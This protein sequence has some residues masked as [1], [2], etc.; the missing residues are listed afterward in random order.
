M[1]NFLHRDWGFAQG[2]YLIAIFPLL[3]ILITAL[4][5]KIVFK[6]KLGRGIANVL[7][8]IAK[9]S[10][11]IH[12]DKTYSQALTSALTVGFGGSA[13][14]EAPIVVTGAAIGSNFA[15]KAG[16]N[17]RERT[18]LLGAGS[19]AG[20]AAV[21]N[22]PITGVIFVIEVLLADMAFSEFIPIIISS[23][24][25]ALCSKVI[26]GENQL[27]V[28]KLK[29][30]FNYANVP[31][32]ILLGILS[33]F[34]SLYYAR[35]TKF[36]ERTFDK[37]A[38]NIFLKAFIG[39]A[40]LFV[41]TALFPS[42][43]GE[44]YESV[45][46]LADGASAQIF[47]HSAISSYLGSEWTFLIFIGLVALIKVIATAL[48]IGSGG[49][50]GNFAPSLFVGAYLGFF[51]S[52]LINMLNFSK[53]PE[54]NFTLVGMAGILSGVFYAPFTAIFLIAELTGGYE[55]I[56][57]LMIVSST[58]FL[59][60]KKFEPYSMDTKKLAEKGRI[61]TE[62]KDLNV[63]TLLETDKLIEHNVKTI[64]VSQSL[65]DL[66]ETIKISKRDVFAVLNVSGQLV[67]I[68]EL[69][70]VRGIMFKPE[71][72]DKLSVKQLMRRPNAIIKANEN[73]RSVMRKFDITKAWNLPIIDEDGIYMGFISKANIFNKYRRMLRG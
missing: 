38:P 17:Y 27:F 34:V 47:D 1:H 60:T 8:D 65:G 37:I 18:L 2:D 68:I 42:L 30:A 31:Y 62:N 70:D 24:C 11:F 61:F 19:A 40:A 25:G 35:A 16:G 72:Y 53:T 20:I 66:V 23:V 51:F 21:F 71:L 10:S 46:L 49:N 69:D 4:V 32:Y 59:I 9:R 3:G 41:L 50:G 57:P 67:G 48:T 28:F 12:R 45:K 39:G 29:E 52:R 15:K 36:I 55:L 5:V 44:G 6:G 64:E 58:A 7:H 22:A 14:L 43:W 13:G 33:G 73:M 56:I 54:S 26:L 63:L